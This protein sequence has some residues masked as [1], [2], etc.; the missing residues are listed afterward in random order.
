MSGK[1][2]L[3]GVLF[4]AGAYANE[5]PRDWDVP[6]TVP[7]TV[8]FDRPIGVAKLTRQD[9]G[10]ITAVCEVLETEVMALP[11][12]RYLG[13]S[14]RKNAMPTVVGA[15]VIRRNPDAD[16]PPYRI[17]SCGTEVA[18]LLQPPARPA[19]SGPPQDSSC[20]SAK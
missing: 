7:L 8:D 17:T 3:D 11:S 4:R 12:R 2:R 9:D 19:V 1:I 13:I 16:L 6:D 10:T 20:E 5:D 14:V 18:G 15:A